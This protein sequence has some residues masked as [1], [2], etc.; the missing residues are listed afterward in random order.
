MAKTT[1]ELELIAAVREAMPQ[2]GRPPMSPAMA[3][4]IQKLGKHIVSEFTRIMNST[5]AGGHTP[6]EEEAL[7]DYMLD[8]IARGAGHP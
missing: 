5:D 6:Q 8:F 7:W 4:E 3:K 2:G 1:T